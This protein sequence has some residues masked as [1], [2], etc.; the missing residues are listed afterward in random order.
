LPLPDDWVE[1]VNRPRTEAELE[2]LHRAVLRG[3][4]F[5]SLVWQQR[6][7]KRLGLEYTLRPPGRPKKRQRTGPVRP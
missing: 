1:Q 2:A 6:M 7:A 4:P 5:E 3:C